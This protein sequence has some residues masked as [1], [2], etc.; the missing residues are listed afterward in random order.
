MKQSQ[1][2]K[3]DRWDIG[4]FEKDNH[5]YA[6]DFEEDKVNLLD[7]NS[8]ILDSESPEQHEIT[9]ERNKFFQ[10]TAGF[11]L[12]VDFNTRLASK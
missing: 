11:P 6:T 4:W 5:L 12:L 9:A 3:E 7:D 10:S 1:G 8:Q 2:V